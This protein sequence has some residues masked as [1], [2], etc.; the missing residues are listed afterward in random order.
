MNLIKTIK[1]TVDMKT[2]TKSE[3]QSIYASAKG[4]KQHQ[5]SIVND[6]KTFF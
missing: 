5:A 6:I 2:I 4:N 1:L 3:T